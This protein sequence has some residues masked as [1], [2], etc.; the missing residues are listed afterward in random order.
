MNQSSSSLNENVEKNDEMRC[1][2]NSEIK[3]D[4]IKFHEH[5]FKIFKK[6]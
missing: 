6:L 4:W 3:F 5:S 2:F 1:D